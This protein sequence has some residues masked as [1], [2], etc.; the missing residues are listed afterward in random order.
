VRLWRV[1]GLLVHE[2]RLEIDGVPARLYDPGGAS[3]LLLLG[4]GGA[5]SKDSERFVALSRTFA[6]QTGLAVVCIDAV[7]HGERRPTGDGAASAGLPPRWHTTSAGRMVADWEKTAEAL[8]SIGPA[9]A[10]IGF[11]MGMIFGA[12]TVAAM[13]SIR[14]A[15]FVVGGIPSG[16]GIDDPPLRDML[17]AAASKLGHAEVLMLNVT[18]D[19]VVRTEDTHAF[20]DAIPG[21]RKRL[22]FWEG[23]HDEWPAEAI[24]QAVAFVNEHTG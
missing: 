6:E 17:L 1:L 2:T 10:Y 11:S 15:V 14:A 5:H 24:R 12:P 21:R 18:R 8:S 20:F 7:D 19:E 4:H 16:A 9:V 23:N 3:G 22:M 13:P